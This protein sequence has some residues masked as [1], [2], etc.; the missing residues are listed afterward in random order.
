L[1]LGGER[2]IVVVPHHE[3]VRPMRQS[4]RAG[5]IEVIAGVKSSGKSEELSRRIR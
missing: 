2:H 1:T 3:P 4:P 5:T